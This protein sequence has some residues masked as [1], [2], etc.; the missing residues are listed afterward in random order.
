M[1]GR[2]L[3]N[4][5]RL[6]EAEAAMREAVSRRPTFGDAHRDLA[7]LV[8]MR[9][10]D[11]DATVASLAKAQAAHP[12]SAELSIEYARALHYAGR[13]ELAFSVLTDAVRRAP[14]PDYMLEIVASSVALM[15]GKSAEALDHA[16]RAM[17]IRPN[18]IGAGLNACDAYLGLGA[19]GHGGQIGSEALQ[20]LSGGPAHR[21]PAGHRL[22][23]HRR[24]APQ[25]P[26][27]LRRH[28]PA[29]CDRHSAAAG[30]ICRP[31]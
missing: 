28:G 7:Q 14:A 19:G 23:G 2:T 18:D 26:L 12:G 20:R 29:L 1:L 15:T 13:S 21:L 27:R 9:S 5:N 31:T 25:G 10:G 22:A 6:D 17:M 8:W 16:T 4:L 11:A 3:M 30:P 24:A